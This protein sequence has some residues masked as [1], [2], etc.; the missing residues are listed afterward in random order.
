MLKQTREGGRLQSTLAAASLLITADGDGPVSAGNAMIQLSSHYSCGVQGQIDASECIQAVQV[1]VIW[2]NQVTNLKHQIAAGAMA[3]ALTSQPG[4]GWKTVKTAPAASPSLSHCGSGR[5]CGFAP[6][7]APCS[8]LCHQ[9]SASHLLGALG[10][11]VPLHTPA[12]TACS[13]AAAA[14]AVTGTD[15]EVLTVAC[16]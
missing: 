9:T 14:A 11:P 13:G 6:H 4:K 5:P 16:C 7:S 12:R 10:M 2:G 3:A 1:K 15:T 8:A